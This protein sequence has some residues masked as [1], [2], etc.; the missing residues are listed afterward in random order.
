MLRYLPPSDLAVTRGIQWLVANQTIKSEQ[1]EGMSWP[2]DAYVGSGFPRF[3]YFGFPYY[4]HHHAIQAF[5][6]YL[7]YS[8]LEI[9][10]T[11]GSY[12]VDIPS[13]ILCKINRP[14]SS[15][16]GSDGEMSR[17]M[18]LKKPGPIESNRGCALIPLLKTD[19][20]HKV[21]GFLLSG[22]AATSLYRSETLGW[23]DLQVSDPIVRNLGRQLEDSPPSP[24]I[25]VLYTLTNFLG[26]VF[27]TLVATIKHILGLFDTVQTESYVEN[28]NSARQA[29]I[30]RG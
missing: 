25:R 23:D 13:T 18:A 14:D 22:V 24:W 30:K 20:K 9:I 15:L 6:G 8:A 2:S 27:A 12:T 17:D 11:K 5:S 16:V 7:Q 28:I 19:W 3:F 10:Q 21:T 26:M 1:G 29:R 4:H